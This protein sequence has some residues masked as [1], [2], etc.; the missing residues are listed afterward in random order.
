V[1]ERIVCLLPWK[2]RG[3]R[4]GAPSRS[5]WHRT[6]APF[7]RG[8]RT[9]S[10]H[11]ASLSAARRAGTPGEHTHTHTHTH[12]EIA[13]CAC[14]GVC[15]C[16][17]VCW[18]KPYLLKLEFDRLGVG[19]GHG[20]CDLV[21]DPEGLLFCCSLQQNKHAARH[22]GDTSRVLNVHR[23]CAAAITSVISR[24]PTV[25]SADREPR[26]PHLLSSLSVFVGPIR[27]VSRLCSGSVL[28]QH[29]ILWEL[30]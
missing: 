23:R 27:E 9:C 21:A 5:L 12:T 3:S 14:E 18:G 25:E 19:G 29:L 22:T 13:V 30:H 10:P 20:L 15:V 28:I 4:R 8:S 26:P 6:R 2:Q 7:G 11:S 24:G 17:C 1:E 16:V